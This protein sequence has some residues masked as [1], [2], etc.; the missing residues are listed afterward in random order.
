MHVIPA[1]LKIDSRSSGRP[2]GM[3]LISRAAATPT[4]RAYQSASMLTGIRS[5]RTTGH[6]LEAGD[7]NRLRCD[8][9]HWR[10]PRPGRARCAGMVDQMNIER[11]LIVPSDWIINHQVIIAL[12]GATTV[13]VGAVAAI[14]ARYLFPSRHR[15]I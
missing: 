15:G 13:Q 10:H 9:H 3:L 1:G 6:P 11:K 14:I 5:D 2:A 12:L 8:L 7:S 4:L